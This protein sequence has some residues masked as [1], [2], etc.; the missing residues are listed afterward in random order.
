[1]VAGL[2]FLCGAA[3]LV[4]R[5]QLLIMLLGLELMVNAVNVGLVYTAGRLQDGAGMAAALL[6]VAVAAAEAVV[7]LSLIIRLHQAGRGA[8][9][10]SVMEL[11]G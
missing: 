2:I 9:S 10:S 3:I 4:L 8:E 11:K 6:I 7:G 5:R 1:M